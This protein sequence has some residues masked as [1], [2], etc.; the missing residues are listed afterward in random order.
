[1]PHAQASFIS[2]RCSWLRRYCAKRVINCIRRKG[3]KHHA[4]RLNDGSLIRLVD[5]VSCCAGFRPRPPA[6]TDAP[7]FSDRRTARPAHSH[8]SRFRRSGLSSSGRRCLSERLFCWSCRSQQPFQ[9]PPATC[10]QF[11]RGN[12][13]HPANCAGEVAWPK[14]RIS[15]ESRRHAGKSDPVLVQQRGLHRSSSR[16]KLWISGKS[17]KW[18]SIPPGRCERRTPARRQ[19]HAMAI[20]HNAQAHQKQRTRRGECGQ[21]FSFCRAAR[22]SRRKTVHQPTV[23]FPGKAGCPW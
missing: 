3:F 21:A 7:D 5:A 12:H 10:G 9:P 19:R 4:K 16:R 11:L 2:R 23:R 8:S 6:R 1:M 14:P 18:L 22:G 13:R 20:L 15:G 17:M